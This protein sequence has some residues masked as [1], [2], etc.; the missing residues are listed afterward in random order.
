MW[1]LLSSSIML[2]HFQPNHS[3]CASLAHIARIV[4]GTTAVLLTGM[5]PAA[6][7][8]YDSDRNSA[9]G[10][11]DGAGNGWNTTGTNTPWFNPLDSSLSAWNNANLDIAV[12]GGGSSGTAGT[13]TVGT[14]TAG[15]IIFNTPFAGNYTLNGGII[16]LGGTTPSIVAN[17]NATINSVLAGTNGL[18]KSG[19]GN[20]T[21]A[22]G[23]ANTYTGTT[24]VSGGFLYMN[25]TSGVNA[26]GGDVVINGGVLA[27]SQSNMVPDTASITLISGGLQMNGL[28]ETIANL[29]IQG[30]NSNHD[31]GFTRN[32]RR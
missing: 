3:G 24:N 30:G 10:I 21:L 12:F 5:M 16:T 13:I 32:R 25:K 2:F 31:G 1:W 14:V 7:L 23:S 6:Q 8:T 22:G 18:T 26:V 27:W 9:N 15:G 11:T 4:L 17:A 28:T 29:T 20:L 19:A